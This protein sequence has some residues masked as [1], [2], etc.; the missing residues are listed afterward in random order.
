MSDFGLSASATAFI[1]RP[2]TD[3][4]TYES[5]STLSELATAFAC[6]GDSSSNEIATRQRMET[7]M[8]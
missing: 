4:T 1:V 2:S 7:T 5:S 8:A 3:V 6:S